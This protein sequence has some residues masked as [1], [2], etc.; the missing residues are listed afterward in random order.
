M[1]DVFRP[2]LDVLPVPQRALWTSLQG[3]ARMGFVLYGGTAIALRLGHRQS[4]DFD[5]FTERPLAS[6][7]LIAHL[8]FL[9][10]ASV[11]QEAPDTRTFVV[12]PD[13]AESAPVKLSFFGSIDFGRVGW[14]Q[15]TDDGV[16]WVAAT[17]DLL[18][19]KLKVILQ[20]AERKD[21]IDIVCML[22]GGADLAHGLA[23]ARALYGPAFQPSESLK[24]MSWFHDGDLPELGKDARTTLI[25][26][27]SAVRTLPEVS[28][29]SRVL[30]G[31][32]ET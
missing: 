29:R 18:A 6:D 13:A 25:E 1:S 3:C 10:K 15:Q 32:R 2:C 19:T 28:V 12:V 22:R 20:R 27:A 17:E 23:A 26:A 21:Y 16:A 31:E 11:L 5:F 9:R 14:P 8:P 24:A 4:V 30:A 7:K